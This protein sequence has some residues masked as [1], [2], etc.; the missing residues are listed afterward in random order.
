MYKFRTSMS[1]V[2]ARILRALAVQLH[3]NRSALLSVK[4]ISGIYN[5]MADVASRRHSLDRIIFL[6]NF[7]A[8]FPPPQGEFW[9]MFLLS[10]KITSKV[11]SELL[12]IQSTLESWRRLPTKEYVF[13]K[14]GPTSSPSTFQTMTKNSV[15]CHN[16][17][18]LMCWSVSLNM[19]NPEVFLDANNMFV[20]K[21]SKY[22]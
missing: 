7:S 3:T 11:S 22:R 10:N 6:T 13:G 20:R 5:K 4:H 19:C 16:Q 15:H 12:K 2:A 17:K 18:K 8:M 9:M 21:Q 14:L 1:L